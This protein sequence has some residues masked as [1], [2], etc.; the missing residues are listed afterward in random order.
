MLVFE[1]SSVLIGWLLSHAG[2][3]GPST[4]ELKPAEIN[5]NGVFHVFSTLRVKELSDIQRCRRE[6]IFVK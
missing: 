6:D 5:L 2:N 4:Q 3:R 1:I